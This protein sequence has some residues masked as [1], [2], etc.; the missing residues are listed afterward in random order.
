MKRTFI[1]SLALSAILVFFNSCKIDEGNNPTEPGTG[2]EITISGV[3]IDSS[4]NAGIY[5]ALVRIMDGSTEL[6]A[7]TTNNT[8]NYSTKIN[9]EQDQTVDVL[10]IKEGYYNASV[11]VDVVLDK[12]VEVSPI[13]LTAQSVEVGTVSI[14]GH[15][16]DAK[17]GESLSNAEIRFFDVGEP[18]GVATSDDGGNFSAT[19]E[20]EGTK[21]L[22]VI[23]LK[24]AYLADTTSVIA[25]SGETATMPTINLR[26]LMDIISGEPASIFLASQTLESIGVTESG[27]PETAK[28]VFEV[29]DSSGN[30]IDLEH[31]VIVNFRFG[32]SPGGGEILAPGFVKTDALGQVTVNLTSGTVAGAVQI[33]GEI[34]FKGEKITSKP[35][36]ITIHGGLPDL[37][38]FA[39]GSDQRNYP[40][41][42]VLNGQGTVTA[43]VGDKY[44]NPVRPETAVYFNTDAAVVQGSALTDDKGL[45]SVT[46]ISGNPLPNDPV[47]GPGF[48]YVTANT[49]DENEQSISTKTRIL[50]SGVPTLTISPTSINIPNGGSQSFTYTVMDQNGNPLAL[51][52]S[53]N[54]QVTTGGDAEA[55]GDIA[56]TLPDVQFGH[57]SFHFTVADTKP[58]DINPNEITI[59]IEV[60]GPNGRASISISG[61]TN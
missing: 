21:E 13:L 31:A 58:D 27:S 12:D 18:I 5:L 20:M 57:T 32:A 56:V 4:S 7:T 38:H 24:A 50:F 60:N 55:G 48:F 22:E 28:I 37:N 44:S 46:I 61:T 49:I 15:V 39:V 54:V 52:N 26:P 19:L 35:V 33:I 42:N 25:V 9:I 36:N 51:G 53:Y 34:D 17:S 11:P 45:A 2:S 10:V 43:L 29:Q 6:S 41:Y 14:V 23:T 8:G 40:Y 47:Y 16:I 59:N 30:P 3:V 1:L